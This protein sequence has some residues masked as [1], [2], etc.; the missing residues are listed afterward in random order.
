[1]NMTRRYMTI[2]L[3][4]LLAGTA[5]SAAGADKPSFWDRISGKKAKRTSGGAEKG[6]YSILLYVCRGPG[7]HIAQA[8][9]GCG[10]ALCGQLRGHHGRERVEAHPRDC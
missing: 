6:N 1:M 5:A 8:T 7:S 9:A 2:A 3:L 10:R 4:M